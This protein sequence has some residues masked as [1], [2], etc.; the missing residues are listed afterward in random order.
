MSVY[1]DPAIV[2]GDYVLVGWSEADIHREEQLLLRERDS[3]DRRNR[4]LRAKQ[5]ASTAIISGLA[6]LIC[7][8]GVVFLGAVIFSWLYIAAALLGAIGLGCFAY[9]LAQY[10]VS[11]GRPILFEQIGTSVTFAGLATLAVSAS[12]VAWLTPSV[13][14]WGAALASVAIMA[15]IRQQRS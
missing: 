10:Q 7:T 13:W 15:W 6:F 14:A 4:I 12:G 1:F 8:P 11:R 2:L 5:E 3:Q 9:G